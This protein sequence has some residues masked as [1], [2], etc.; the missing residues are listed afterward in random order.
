MSR[1]L[2]A[3]FLPR[4]YDEFGVRMSE[5]MGVLTDPEA[6]STC[7][8]VSQCVMDRQYYKGLTLCRKLLDFESERLH[9][10][11]ASV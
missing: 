4:F 3:K 5:F 9:H 6:L 8:A 11:P 2:D 1:Y 10:E 7:V